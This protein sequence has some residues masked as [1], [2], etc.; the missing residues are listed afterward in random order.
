MAEEAIEA[1]LKEMKELGYT[2]AALRRALD[3]RPDF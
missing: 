3:E 1:F 2:K